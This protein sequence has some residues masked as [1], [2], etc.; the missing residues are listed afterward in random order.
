MFFAKDR[1]G[2][3]LELHCA[4]GPGASWYGK[5]AHRQPSPSPGH[6]REELRGALLPWVPSQVGLQA[7]ASGRALAPGS[8]S[9]GSPHLLEAN[10]FLQPQNRQIPTSAAAPREN[11]PPLWAWHWHSS[12]G[13]VVMPPSVSRLEQA[14]ACLPAQGLQL[15]GFQSG[16]HF[17]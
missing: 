1:T 16:D 15:R 4:G 9:L 7:G 5:Q 6:A 14:S 10:I 13:R 3:G 8:S 2:K 12:G 11:I 17:L